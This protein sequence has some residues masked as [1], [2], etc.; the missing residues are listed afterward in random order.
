M[1]LRL[2]KWGPLFLLVSGLAGAMP[3]AGSGSGAASVPAGFGSP[4][5]PDRRQLAATAYFRLNDRISDPNEEIRTNEFVLGF[6]APGFGKRGETI[7]EARVTAKEEVR[8][9]L[10][11]HPK[12]GA[13]YPLTGAFR[14]NDY[15]ERLSVSEEE[16]IQVK[17]LVLD[18]YG[19]L[20]GRALEGS[21]PLIITRLRLARDVGDLAKA[22]DDLYDVRW[23]GKVGVEGVFWV[24]LKEK[25]VKVLAGVPRTREEE[26][27]LPVPQDERA[28][29]NS[30][31]LKE[32]GRLTNRLPAGDVPLLIVRWRMGSDVEGLAKAGED[33]YE[34]RLEGK[35]GVEAVF[36]VNL[37]E[38]K[39]KSIAGPL[40]AGQGAAT[41][42]P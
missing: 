11:V 25:K 32:Y 3:S 40:G 20:T 15:Q 24:N 28:D 35:E 42:R 19:R 33:I 30:L 5:P 2:F 39:V 8:A 23:E 9:I 38:K 34:V 1:P 41:Q 31:V 21:I 7:I 36:W 29:I 12:T 10:W 22:G 16:K 13:V 6:D 26:D 17:R 37:K 14:P 4:P 27:Q 18:E